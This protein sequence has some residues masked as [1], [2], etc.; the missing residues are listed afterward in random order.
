MINTLKELFL[1]IVNNYPNASSQPFAGNPLADMIRNKPRQLI[2][3]ILTNNSL[4]VDSSPGKGNWAEVPWI[5]IINK[6]ETDGAQEGVYV[7]YLFSEDMKRIYLTFNQGVSRPIKNDGR[8][9]AFQKLA[10][11]AIDIRTNYPLEGFI[12]DN[13]IILAKKGLGADYEKATIYY[14]EYHVVNLS[15]NEALISDLKKLLAFYDNY[16][17]ES[18]VLTEGTD[19]TAYI[20][21]VE[22]G[23]RLLK[24]HYI[25]ERNPKVIK[26]AKRIALKRNGELR[27]EVCNFSFSEH[28]GE[29]GKDFIE[30]HHKIPISQMED[31]QRTSPEDIVLLCSNCHKMVHIKMPPISI[32]E[33]K[34]ICH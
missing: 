13:N 7:V 19:F 23:K 32:E 14:K 34:Q 24:K 28:Y 29:R 33:L 5:A 20:G 21:Q 22:E 10:A 15:D 30:G 12:P 8:K 16:I 31:G 25:R 4:F 9:L 6:D 18:S 27:C 1:E 3:P 26:E 2:E 11:K 17:L